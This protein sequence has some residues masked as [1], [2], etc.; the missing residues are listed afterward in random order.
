[1]Q[2]A[3]DPH[4]M[5]SFYDSLKAV[6]GLRD[7]GSI[8]VRSKDGKT[9][10]T[11]RVG[12]LSRW[13]EHFHGVLN[14]TSTFDP[15]LLSELPVWD[16]NHDL[17]Q[18]PDS[19][20]VLR[21]INQISSGK[22]PGPDGLPPELFKSG[23]PDIVSI[24]YGHPFK[25]CKLSCPSAFIAST[26]WHRVVNMWNALPEN[27]VA[28]TSLAMFKAQLNDFDLVWFTSVF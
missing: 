23:G 20:E 17:M 22:A 8:P 12:I 14:Q 18:P 6:Y 15:T 13:A 28:A 2:F 25:L 3:A 4:D 11:D 21:A 19:S 24:R 27:I 1:M 26:F 7:T 5:K 16:A 9:L 10:I